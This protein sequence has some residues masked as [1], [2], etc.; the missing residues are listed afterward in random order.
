MKNILITGAPGSGKTTIIKKLFEIFKEFNPVGFYTSE[1][2]ENGVKTGFELVSS[3]GD[4][5][6][7]ASIALKSRYVVGKYKVDIK[8]FD[9]FLENI[10]AREKKTG[11][12]IFDGITK[13]ECQSRKFPKLITER[14]NADKPVVASI[15]HRGTGFISDIKKRDD[16]K[17]IELNEDNFNQ[18]LKELTMQLRDILLG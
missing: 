12:Y 15:A 3:Y 10:F 5:R 7:L 11:L 17:L 6:I 1:I 13:M 14:F 18:R 9:E 2:V 4:S 16:I 8:G